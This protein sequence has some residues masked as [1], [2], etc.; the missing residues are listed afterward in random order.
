V[1]DK[2][3]GSRTTQLELSELCFKV[4]SHVQAGGRGSAHERF[5]KRCPKSLLPGTMQNH[6]EHQEMI[7]KRHENQVNLSLK[8]DRTAVDEFLVKDRVVIQN[9]I[10]GEW[11][12]EGVIISSRRADDNSIQSFE[13]QTD[14]G[15]VKLRN[16]RFL[17]HVCKDDAHANRHVQFHQP[18]QPDNTVQE[19]EAESGR[20][21]RGPMTRARARS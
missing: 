14:S 16:K 15:T 18:S 20:E 17:K 10:S 5:H 7:K 1:L 21:Q 9:N 19:R 12:E 3:G 13:V 11:D 2:R 6:V 4:N 8:K